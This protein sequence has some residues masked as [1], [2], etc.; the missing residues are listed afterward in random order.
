MWD[1]DK[2]EYK[3]VK[4]IK[5]KYEN[6]LMSKKGVVGCGIGYKEIKGKKTNILSIVCYVEKKFPQRN[7][8][9]KIW[10]LKNSRGFPSTFKRRGNS[11]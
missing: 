9:I 1:K 3:R 8:Q 6:F 5:E 7:Y 2:E 11:K 4:E 10:F